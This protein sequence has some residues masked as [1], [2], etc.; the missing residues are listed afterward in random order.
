MKDIRNSPEYNQWKNEVKH[1]DGNACRRC[2]FENNLHVH[3]IKPFKKYPEFAIE[4][5]NGLTLC[6]NCHSLLRGKE[7]STDLQTFLGDDANIGEQLKAID[8]SFS[9]Y[10][11]RKLHSETQRTRDNAA[12]ALFAHLK[13][14]PNSLGE[15]LSL[16]IDVV[17]SENWSDESHTK[18]QAI[19][20]LKTEASNLSQSTPNETSSSSPTLPNLVTPET[21]G[22]S[23]VRMSD[24]TEVP[25]EE[26]VRAAL[27]KQRT[28][29]NSERHR[30]PP[31][32]S[33]QADTL[34]SVETDAPAESPN[35][36]NEM[37]KD[38]YQSQKM[39]TTAAMQAIS[40]YEQRIEQQ[41]VEQRRIAEQERLRQENEKREAEKRQQEEII[42]QY[43]S[44][45]A[46]ERHQKTEALIEN[47]RGL[48]AISLM[49]LPLILLCIWA[50]A[51]GGIIFVIL[52]FGYIAVSGWRS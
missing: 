35:L 24:G 36:K 42:S 33:K 31:D 26:Y 50:D 25:A 2:G 51:P 19:K 52:F 27:N 30:I 7:E 49:A 48:G 41:R 14:Y 40:R 12:S 5:D 6:G 23:V 32:A 46:Y 11:Q 34:A 18:R 44:L 10:L 9:N 13:V 21:T 3:H 38:A 15:M 1:R 17:D 28:Y 39:Q 43:G 29:P 8:G 47:L 37:S 16:L 22:P 4:L 20:W 45:E